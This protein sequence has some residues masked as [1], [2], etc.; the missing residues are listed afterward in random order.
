MFERLREDVNSVFHRDPAARNFFE[1]LTTYPGVHA[2]LM[3]RLSHALWRRNIKWPA[4]IIASFARWF[5]GIEIHPGAHIGRRFFIDHGMG[6]VI[7]ETAEI[8]DDVTLYHS[9]TLGGTSW[10]NGKRHPTLGNGVIV[11]AGAKILGPFTVGAGAKI[12]SNAVVTKEVPPGATLVGIPARIV[13]RA[14][15]DQEE[16][17]TYDPAKR[18]AIQDKFGFDAYGVSEEM[19]DP[20]AK[21]IR[22]LLDHMHAVD[23][24]LNQICG[25]LNRLDNSFR[26]H[27]MPELRE[28]DFQEAVAPCSKEGLDRIG[29]RADKTQAPVDPSLDQ[30]LA[31][32]AEIS[33]TETGLTDTAATE[34]PLA[35]TST[36]ALDRH[37]LDRQEKPD[38]IHSNE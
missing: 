15:P 24:R 37:D 1:V 38:K 28:E 16:K 4:K 14:D 11:G 29:R 27:A 31:D 7:G 3:H 9:V 17:P 25:A 8:G 23:G 35:T 12:G 5:T 30:A 10:Q 13:K 36:E 34:A 33:S 32:T 18:Q 19:P 22:G 21:S 2:L 6:V 20:V 26:S